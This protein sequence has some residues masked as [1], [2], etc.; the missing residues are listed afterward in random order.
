MLGC[1]LCNGPNLVALDRPFIS[2]NLNVCYKPCRKKL[3]Q[4]MGE[5]CHVDELV[6]STTL[7]YKRTAR[8]I[9]NF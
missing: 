4:A 2:N 5:V 6:F 3:L 9:F 8:V 1:L 7:S